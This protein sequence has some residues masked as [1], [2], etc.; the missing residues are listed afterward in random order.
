MARTEKRFHYVQFLVNED[1]DV[2]SATCEFV[3]AHID[4]RVRR[5]SAIPAETAAAFDQ[6][7]EEHNQLPWPAP[8]CGSMKP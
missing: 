4:M 6:L 1:K 8:L 2:L 3:G 7:V 5:M